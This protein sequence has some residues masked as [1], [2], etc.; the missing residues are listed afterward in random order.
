[1]VKEF[2]RRDFLKLASASGLVT[3]LS[4]TEKKVL[5]EQVEND[6]WY[7]VEDELYGFFKSFILENNH[8]FWRLKKDSYLCWF[9]HPEIDDKQAVSQWENF[10]SYMLGKNV[11]IFIQSSKVHKNLK[12][13][14]RSL[15][16]KGQLFYGGWS[17]RYVSRTLK[18]EIPKHQNIVLGY[19]MGYCVKIHVKYLRRIGVPTDQISILKDYSFCCGKQKCIDDAVAYYRENKIPVVEGDVSKFFEKIE[20]TPR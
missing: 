18:K 4:D 7:N 1:M 6:V 9:I 13:E 15:N 16:N 12:E 19:R 10:L 17:G 8:I 5:Q 14:L 20:K 3:I 11:M 2:P